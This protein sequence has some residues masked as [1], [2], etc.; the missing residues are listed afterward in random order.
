[1]GPSIHDMF[2]FSFLTLQFIQ[3]QILMSL[4]AYSCLFNVSNTWDISSEWLREEDYRLHL[5]Q[6]QRNKNPDTF[7]T[8]PQEKM[9]SL[10]GLVIWVLSFPNHHP[11]EAPPQKANGFP[12]KHQQDQKT[13]GNSSLLV[14]CLFISSKFP[15]STY[16]AQ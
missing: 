6:L 1:M 9:C 5:N 10:I 15:I 11:F 14:T 4:I 13:A 16:I 7:S 8:S 12:E 3:F 2:Q